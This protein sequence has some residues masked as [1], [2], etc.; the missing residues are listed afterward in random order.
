VHLVGFIIRTTN[1]LARVT[2]P[3]AGRPGDRGFT[4]I[5]DSGFFPTPLE[6]HT[7]SYTMVNENSTRKVK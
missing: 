6:A 2:E 1:Q 7:R 4:S 5:R 3:E